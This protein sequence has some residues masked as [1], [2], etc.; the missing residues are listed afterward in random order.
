MASLTKLP[1][2]DSASGT[3]RESDTSR[4]AAVARPEPQ[5]EPR[6]RR[7]ES[8]QLFRT[9]YFELISPY[10]DYEMAGGRV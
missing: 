1:S 2:P 10:S 6:H 5:H 7:V 9:V 3:S 4:S 8:L